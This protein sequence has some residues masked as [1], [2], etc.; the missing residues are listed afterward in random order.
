MRVRLTLCAVLAAALVGPSLVAQQNP[1]VGKWNITGTGADSH[2][3]YFLD[4]VD[5]GDHLE[6]K[7]LDR[8]AHAT[9]VS[10]IRVENGELRWQYGGSGETLPKP[11]CGPLYHGKI[12]SGKLVGSHELPGAPCPARGGGAP[13]PSTQPT[14]TVSWVGVRQPTF[15]AVNANG[16]H[17][18]GKPVVIVGKGIGKETWSGLTAATWQHECADRWTVTDGVLKNAVGGRGELP[19]CNI[20]TKERFKDF[21]V[22]AD[23]VLDPGQNSGFYVRGRYE[24]QL[25]LPNPNGRGGASAYPGQLMDIYGWTRANAPVAN[26]AGQPQHLEVTAVGN[27]VTVVFNGKKVHDNQVLYAWTG[28]ALDANEDQPGPIMIQG[29]HSLVSITKLVVTPITKAG[30]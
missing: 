4:V 13:A 2:N 25:M 15:P 17:T 19:T 11:A 27:R 7:F 24:L 21:K 29:D 28:G 18:Y 26:P 14:R 8:S 30:M 6:A 20:F 22:E 3:I 12:V 5:K 9:P 1:Y 16:A 10:W 23:I